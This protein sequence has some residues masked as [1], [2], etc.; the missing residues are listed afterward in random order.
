V[1]RAVVAGMLGVASQIG[2]K[3]VA[4]GVETAEELRVLTDLGV[5]CGQGYYLGRPAPLG[6][7]SGS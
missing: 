6:G 3:V 1:K 7:E 4:E 5:D 2:A